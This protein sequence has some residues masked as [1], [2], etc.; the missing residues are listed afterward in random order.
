MWLGFS[1]HSRDARFSTL[2]TEHLNPLRTVVLLLLK[3]ETKTVLFTSTS[4][5]QN[6]EKLSH[7][8][9]LFVN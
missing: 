4:I 2:L 1:G 3:L 9:N 7:L 5:N 8:Y 6:L